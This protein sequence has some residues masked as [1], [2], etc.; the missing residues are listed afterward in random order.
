MNPCENCI[1]K[2]VCDSRFNCE[3]YMDEF[4]IDGSYN[5]N[6]VDTINLNK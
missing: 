1:I 4:F 2:I 6:T 5:Q 3:I